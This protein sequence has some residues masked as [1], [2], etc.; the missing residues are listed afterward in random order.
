VKAK[1]AWTSLAVKPTCVQSPINVII[2]QYKEGKLN[3]SLDNLSPKW[4]KIIAE[5]KST[6]SYNT[7]RALEAFADNFG[8]DERG[9]L[10]DWNEEVQALRVM[11]ANTDSLL[12]AKLI[13]KVCAIHTVAAIYALMS[14]T[15]VAS[16]RV[17]RRQ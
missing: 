15:H 5:D 10:R 13:H 16:C 9:P 17:L 11:D 14:G 7:A 2:T 12:R 1:E 8:V 6:H 4:L 3:K